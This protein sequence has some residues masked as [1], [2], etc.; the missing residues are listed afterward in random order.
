MRELARVT[1]NLPHDGGIDAMNT[2]TFGY[3]SVLFATVSGIGVF[4]WAWRRLNM[5]WYV[6]APG[7]LLFAAAAYIAFW[8]AGLNAAFVTGMDMIRP[9]AMINA[10][11]ISV[12]WYWLFYNVLDY[13]RRRRNGP[14]SNVME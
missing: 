13:A 10:L 7:A 12:G 9:G 8:W 2:L 3:I 5:P 11:I 1:E 4:Y 14:K 6:N